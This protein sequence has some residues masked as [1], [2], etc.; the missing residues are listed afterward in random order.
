[1]PF[2]HC[3]VDYKQ[4][5]HRRVMEQNEFCQKLKPIPITKARAAKD[6][7]PL[8]PTELTCFRAILGALLWLCQTRL[9]L[10]CDVVLQQQEISKATIGSLKTA[11]SIVT[12]A[13]K[14]AQSCGLHFPPIDPPLKMAEVC[15]SSHASKTSSYAQ[16]GVLILLMHDCKMEV[17]ASDSPHYKAIVKAEESMS[18]F[19]HILASVSHKA[20]RISSS[21][22]TAETLSATLGK[23][24]GQL[25]AIRLTEVFGVGIQ[26]SL[27]TPATLSMLSLIHI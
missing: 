12:R 13:K 26:T 8:T 22:S 16:E 15:D 1:M 14:Y 20:K 11:N 17:I 4:T 25:V 27:R 23:E 10:V 24:L 2:T 6:S 9:D 5:E 21:T 18:D 7:E 19:C 3:G